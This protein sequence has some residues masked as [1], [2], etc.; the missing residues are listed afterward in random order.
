MSTTAATYDLV[1]ST[2][3]V[4]DVLALQKQVQK[5]TDSMQTARKAAGMSSAISAQ[6]KNTSFQ[7][8]DLAV[9]IASGTS[10]TQAFSQQLP[11]LLSGFGLFGA[12]AGTAAAVLIPFASNMLGFGQ[13]T[14]AAGEIADAAAEQINKLS[15][16]LKQAGEDL[17]SA[18]VQAG[19]YSEQINRLNQVRVSV[20]LAKSQQDLRSAVASVGDEIKNQLGTLDSWSVS[21]GNVGQVLSGVRTELLAAETGFSR[22][23]GA[24]TA[25]TDRAREIAALAGGLR[26]L[27]LDANL[28]FAEARALYD[29]FASKNVTVAVTEFERLAAMLQT[30]GMSTEGA[31]SASLGLLDLIAK[32][33]GAAIDYQRNLAVAIERQQRLFSS[34]GSYGP[35]SATSGTTVKPSLSSED[36]KA[37]NEA[38]AAA[39]KTA[40]EYQS[41]VA[42]IERG[43]TP[44]ASAQYQLKE[45]SANLQRFQS[46]MTPEQ[47]T[48]AA[49]Y[50]DSIR[51]RIDSIT[52]KDRW[53]EMSASIEAVRTPLMAFHEQI[54]QIGSS[55]VEAFGSGLSDAFTALVEGAKS[56]D[57]AFKEFAVSFLKQI[58]QMIVK[59]AVL[60][61]IQSALGGMLGGQSALRP[62]LGLGT[63][64]GKGGVFRGGRELKKFA[65]GG[66]VNGPTMFPMSSGVG[67]MGEAGP[68]AIVPLTRRNGK[69]G[70]EAAA[71]V[72][73]IINNAGAQVTTRQ[74]ARG[75]TDVLI[76]A[77]ATAIT[78]GGN[79][80]DSAIQRGY[81]LRR[82]GR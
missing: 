13:Q 73:N 81:G 64:Y 31:K 77:M 41:F 1:V 62:L 33:S 19:A 8:Q 17:S 27:G 6:I 20:E 40:T 4:G 26:E 5:F 49:A 44:L 55:V 48:Q 66:V 38:A 11:Q 82:A 76:E 36:R 60:F 71:P 52:F 25:T 34:V 79:T 61:A 50:L 39:R 30:Y 35:S 80:L 69:L 24:L 9:Q 29:A 10:A 58:T 18:T 57:E 47:Q 42:T 67:L 37:A 68:E 7:V 14:K 78:R 56:A 75:E 51:A 63:V 16:A 74:N 12:V 54:Q 65:N 45:V 21:N 53:Q 23:R 2:K 46:Q 3:G 32:L 15:S 70:V 43:T 59:A 28:A 22:F 72:I